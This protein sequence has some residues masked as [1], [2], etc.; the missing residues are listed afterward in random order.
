MRPYR[1][2]TTVDLT[3]YTSTTSVTTSGGGDSSN[4]DDQTV[5]ILVVPDSS[6][7]ELG[8]EQLQELLPCPPCERQDV[9]EVEPARPPLAAFPGRRRTFKLRWL[10]GLLAGREIRAPP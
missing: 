9:I 5:I 2:D 3:G 8:A 6:A 4:E 10:A 7:A 1:D